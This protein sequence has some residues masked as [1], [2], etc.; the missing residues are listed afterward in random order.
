MGLG[1]GVPDVAGVHLELLV[2]LGAS[3]P[4]SLCSVSLETLLSRGP[5]MEEDAASWLGGLARGIGN[6]G[7]RSGRGPPP[8]ASPAP[9]GAASMLC[10][11]LSSG[12][13]ERHGG[14]MCAFCPW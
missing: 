8:L 9:V 1:D 13:P 2:A 11:S 10:V 14:L 6:S 5:G 3:V 7:R 12:T 4:P